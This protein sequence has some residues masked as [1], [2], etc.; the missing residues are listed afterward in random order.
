MLSCYKAARKLSEWES[1][2]LSPPS[3]AK[4]NF[5]TCFLRKFYFCT[6]NCCKLFSYI[7]GCRWGEFDR[8]TCKLC[9][10]NSHKERRL[11]QWE[12]LLY[13]AHIV[14]NFGSEKISERRGIRCKVKLM[15]TYNNWKKLELSLIPQPS[16][17]KIQVRELTTRVGRRVKRHRCVGFLRC[18]LISTFSIWYHVGISLLRWNKFRK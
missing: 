16:Q 10:L 15:T 18:R 17:L 11:N 5:L 8:E 12:R 9:A 2:F 6:E 7:I 13:L 14:H 3:R 4:D 1:V